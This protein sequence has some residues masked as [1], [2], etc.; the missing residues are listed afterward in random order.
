MG[1][2]MV[3]PKE[4]REKYLQRRESDIAVLHDALVTHTFDE[5]KRI[6]HQL[7]GNAASFGYN[8]LESIAIRLEKAGE[9]S[10]HAEASALLQLFEKWYFNEKKSMV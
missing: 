2:E 5:F 3:V 8:E 4:L 9:K 10:D 1:I 7:K 6:G